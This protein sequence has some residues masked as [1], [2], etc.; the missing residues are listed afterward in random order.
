MFK[1]TK[2]QT[3]VYA[4]RNKVNGK[5]Y[6][7]SAAICIKT[8][9]RGHRRTL[10]GGRHANKILQR[11]WR[12]Y[13]EHLFEFVVLELCFAFNCVEREQY[14]IDYY[15]AAD[16]RF[17]YNICTVAGS[18]LG[19]T[20]G[21]SVRDRISTKYHE[22]YPPEKRFWSNVDKNGPVC[23]GLGRCWNWMAGRD[24]D[25]YGR[26]RVYGRRTRTHR[27]SWIIHNGS[28]PNDLRVLHYCNNF[29]CVNPGHLYLG[30]HSDQMDAMVKNGLTAQ[31]SRNGSAKLTECDVKEVRKR[32]GSGFETDEI[33]AIANE[34]GVSYATIYD[35][36][37][38]RTWKHLATE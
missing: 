5:I 4:I 23:H 3:G 1:L 2:W 27:Y 35:I 26:I 16:R 28:I 13:G 11:A 32:C 34:L 31:G 18:T 24:K 29:I 15:K 6:I 9:W 22:A 14:W 37:I 10:R 25:G 17:G 19:R 33:H 30:D 8:R 7:G 20:H 36:V 12:K 38:M 21:K